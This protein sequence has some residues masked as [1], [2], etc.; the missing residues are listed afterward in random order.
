[1]SQFLCTSV[2]ELKTIAQSLIDKYPTS[3]LFAFK[4][5]MG[6]GKTT[7]IKQ[8]CQCL[9]IDES[10]TSPT[11]SIVNE[12]VGRDKTVYHFDFYRLK[13]SQE[14]VNLGFDEYILSGNYC[15]MEWPNIIQ[16]IL[17]PNTVMVNIEVLEN[18]NSRVFTF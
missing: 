6:A 16:E 1:M 7:F 4:G 3:R 13:N 12:Y 10:V 8:V 2:D 9:G 5:E 15:L 18:N 17:P 11:F 14:A